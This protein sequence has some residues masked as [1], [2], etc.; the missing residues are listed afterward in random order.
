MLAER[1]PAIQSALAEAGLDGWFFACFQLNDPVGLDLLGLSGEGK[2]VTR[3]CY[4]LIPR[5]GEPKK[6][7]H[8]LEPAM[9]DH[10][11]GTKS[12]YTTW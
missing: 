3:R 5:E 4:Y 11:P 12:S 9:L 1:I 10:L 2:L 7:V 6:L 8:D